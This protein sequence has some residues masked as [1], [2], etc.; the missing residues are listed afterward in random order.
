MFYC[1]QLKVFILLKQGWF[2][3]KAQY[4]DLE[5]YKASFHFITC[6]SIMKYSY[7]SKT[8]ITVNK[9]LELMSKYAVMSWSKHVHRAH[10]RINIHN[11]LSRIQNFY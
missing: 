11:N 8:F 5:T 3:Y 6:S 1:F 2:E 7:N 9:H 4:R 10:F